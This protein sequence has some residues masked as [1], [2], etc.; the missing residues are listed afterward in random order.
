MDE[1]LGLPHSPELVEMI[2]QI[3]MSLK[4]AQRIQIRPA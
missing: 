1:A 3:R 4:D 2:A